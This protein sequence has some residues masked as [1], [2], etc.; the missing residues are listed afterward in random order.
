MVEIIFVA[1]NQED[2]ALV[3]ISERSKAADLASIVYGEHFRN[4]EVRAGENQ[5]LQVDDGT[6]VLP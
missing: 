5:G 6:S 1:R 2:G 3:T 4:C